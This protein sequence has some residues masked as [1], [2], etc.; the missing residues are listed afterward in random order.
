MTHTPPR[1]QL[2]P[3]H[4]LHL[5]IQ[6][7]GGLLQAEQIPRTPLAAIEQGSACGF[8]QRHQILRHHR[9]GRHGPCHGPVLAAAAGRGAAGGF[10]SLPAHLDPFAEAQ[11]GG[12]GLQGLRLA[13]HGVH[14]GEAGGGQGD[15]QRQARE[16]ATGAHIEAAQRPS[17]AVELFTPGPE[18]VVHLG[19]P[20]VVAVDQTGEVEASIPVTQELLQGHQQLQLLLGGL[21]AQAVPEFGRHRIG[22]DR[23]PGPACWLI[24]G[25]RIRRHSCSTDGGAL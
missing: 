11:A 9:C 19:D 17:R 21:P 6:G 4:P 23:L 15:G 7:F 18:A 14:Q 25:S 12:H 1:R 22:R 20:V 3:L 10:R 8:Q 24:A 2:H 16:A 5:G 13:P